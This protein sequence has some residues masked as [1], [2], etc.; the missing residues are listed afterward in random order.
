MG[1]EEILALFQKDVE[2]GAAALVEQYRYLLW[3]VCARRLSD[4]EDIWECVY[5]ALADFC[6]RWENFDRSKGALK[7]YLISIADK[8]AL[9]LYRQNLRWN[10]TK[11]AAQCS[12]V[13]SAQDVQE[14]RWLLACMDGLS[15]KEKRLLCLRYVDGLSYTDIARLLN[16][17]YEQVKK[18]GYRA[19]VKL[20]RLW[21]E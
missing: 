5:S 3:G 12:G 15:E 9:D 4:P 8:K 18:Q 13:P 10:R 6:L 21:K 20:K 14:R 17:P 16:L 11:Q 2:T 1:E 19:F 7:S